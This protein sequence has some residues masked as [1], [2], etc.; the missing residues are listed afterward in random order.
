MEAAEQFSDSIGTQPACGALGV[1]RASLYRKR[2]AT[3]YPQ[4]VKRRPPAARALNSGER[5]AV[6]E[7]LHSERFVDQAP[8]PIYATLLDEGTYLCSIRSMYRILSEQGEVRERRHQLTHARHSKPELLATGPNEL[9]SWDITKLKG[10]VKWT[11]FYLYVILDVFSRYVVGWMVA[12]RER[13]AL[14]RKLITVSC[15]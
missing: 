7:T 2:Q 8:A 5:Q 11:Y 6:L 14:A 12:H 13:A 15:R 3:R 4:P 9:W 10:P 1:S